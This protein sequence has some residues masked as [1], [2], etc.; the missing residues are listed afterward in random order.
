MKKNKI[1]LICLVAIMAALSVVFERFFT[2][3]IGDILK[4][5]LYA[6]P[7]L[8][9]GILHGPLIGFITGAIS[10]FFI[11]IFSYGVSVVTVFYALAP[12]MWGLISGLV[13]KPFKS[14]KL[15][16]NIIG[17]VLAV[18]LAS[19]AANVVN[20][21]AFYMDSLLI[22]DSYFTLTYILTKWPG[23]L[24]TMVIMIVPYCMLVIPI[25]TSLREFVNN[26][27]NCDYSHD[28]NYSN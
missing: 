19:I 23:R 16:K 20:T 4:I 21:I 11:Q 26:K 10:G 24:L 5:T 3:N 8:V 14:E 28:E 6:L 7:L 13:Y 2:I 27:F 15:S 18:V 25:C 9:V 17:Y 22:K 1:Y 12:A